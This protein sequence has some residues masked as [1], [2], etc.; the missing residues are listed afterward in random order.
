M[1]KHNYRMSLHDEIRYANL[2]LLI[3]EAGSQIALA[4]RCDTSEAYISQLYNKLPDSKTGN[5]KAVGNRLARKLE[6]GMHKPVNWMDLDHS[7]DLST[8][9]AAEPAATYNVQPLP[10]RGTRPV[11]SWVRAGHWEDISDPFGPGEA[12]RWEMPLY[13]SGDRSFWLQVDGD[14]MVADGGAAPSFPDGT[15]IHCDPDIGAE[16]GKYVIAKNVMSQKATFKKLTTDG[17]ML[18]LTPLNTRYP[19]MPIDSENIRIIATVT[20]WRIGGKL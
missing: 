15:L 16:P 9:A 10:Q 5:P 7:I 17:M 4:S 1:C 2:L 3:N 6:A 19:T 14:S 13:R 20:E 12:D 11:I 8:P 18:Y